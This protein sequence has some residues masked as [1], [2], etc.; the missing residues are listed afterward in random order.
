[1]EWFGGLS[2]AVKIAVVLGGVVVAGF[3]IWAF[4]VITTML[5][6]GRKIGR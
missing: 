2:D 1:M 4:V 6:I 5:A 3:V